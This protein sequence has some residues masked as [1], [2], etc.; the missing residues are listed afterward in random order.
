MMLNL[1]CFNMK[2]CFILTMWNS[3]FYSD[4][5]PVLI[6]FFLVFTSDTW[7]PRHTIKCSAFIIVSAVDK[8]KY[9][10]PM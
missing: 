8:A 5:N 9:I 2:W 7:F 6:A 1:V 10:M 4:N 3:W